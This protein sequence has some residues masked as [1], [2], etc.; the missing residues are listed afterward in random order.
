[1][2]TGL[3]NFSG[4]KIYPGHGIRYVRNDNKAFTF[5]DN[6]CE[7][8]FLMKRNPR[9]IRWT[10]VYRRMHKKGSVEEAAKKKARRVQ[11]VQRAIVGAS[12]EV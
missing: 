3:C 6:K 9:R 12:L 5:V 11:K 10:Q 2:K 1:M 7:S 8:Y 4:F